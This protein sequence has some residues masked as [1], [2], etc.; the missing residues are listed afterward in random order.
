MS[1]DDL[2]ALGFTGD[3]LGMLN[4]PNVLSVDTTGN[5]ISKFDAKRSHL[6]CRALDLEFR[7]FLLL[8]REPHLSSG[9]GSIN[10]FALST[11]RVL[12]I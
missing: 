6:W 3:V 10:F 9:S 12:T 5:S 11:D 4:E 8:P 7:H 2:H 1:I